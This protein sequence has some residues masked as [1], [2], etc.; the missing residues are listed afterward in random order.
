MNELMK[1]IDKLKLELDNSKEVKDITIINNKILKDKDLLD[2][3][4]KYNTTKDEK[5]KNEILS[6]E[7]F[8]EYKDKEIDL[9]VL[10]LKINNELKKISNKGK[11]NL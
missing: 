8:K 4:S 7:L 3:I 6:N 1:K 5:I 11:C 2:K 9:N 10:I